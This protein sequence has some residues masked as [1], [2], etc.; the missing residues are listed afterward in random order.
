MFF[1][2]FDKD[3]ALLFELHH[4]SKSM[5]IIAGQPLNANKK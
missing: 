3:T 2:L 5:G 4:K 1:R